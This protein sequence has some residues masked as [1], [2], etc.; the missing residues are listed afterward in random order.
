M[1][2]A[3][4]KNQIAGNVFVA[5]ARFAIA[6]RVIV[7]KDE[8][9]S[10]VCQRLFHYLTRRYSGATNGA[11]NNVLCI[12]NLILRIQEKILKTSLFKSRM[13]W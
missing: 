7:S 6:R 3:A 4:G 13:E 12:D 8:R 10:I 11:F 5:L 1:H 2:Y 9:R